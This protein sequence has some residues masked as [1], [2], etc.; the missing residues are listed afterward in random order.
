MKIVNDRDEVEIKRYTV[1]ELDKAAQ[2]PTLPVVEEA[3]EIILNEEPP[4]QEPTKI[5]KPHFTKRKKRPRR[6]SPG[7]IEKSKFTKKRNS[8][9]ESKSS[10]ESNKK[11]KSVKS[12]RSK[13]NTTNSRNTKRFSG[14]NKRFNKLSKRT[15]SQRKR[16]PKSRYQSSNEK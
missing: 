7:K 15:G 16:R 11:N 3:K 6:R 12:K 13:R 9:L 1:E 14:S 10:K 2:E 8:R 5:S 4:D